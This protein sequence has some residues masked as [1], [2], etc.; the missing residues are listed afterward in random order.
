MVFHICGKAL[1]ATGALVTASGVP[2]EFMVNRCRPI[3]FATALS[4]LMAVAVWEAR[5]V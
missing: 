4:P 3:V 5:L 1:G 2:R